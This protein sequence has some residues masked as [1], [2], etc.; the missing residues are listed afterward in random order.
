MFHK[1][2]R[3]LIVLLVALAL[4]LGPA[5]RPASADIYY[6]VIK[7]YIDLMDTVENDGGTEVAVKEVWYLGGWQWRWIAYTTTH[8][9]GYYETGAYIRSNRYY[10]VY[11]VPDLDKVPHMAFGASVY[12]DPDENNPGEKWCSGSLPNG[13]RVP[14]DDW[15]IEQD[16]PQLAYAAQSDINGDGIHDVTDRSII[17]KNLSKVEDNPGAQYPGREYLEWDSSD[18]TE[19]SLGDDAFGALMEL[20]GTI[21]LTN[22]VAPPYEQS[23]DYGQIQAWCNGTSLNYPPATENQWF[24]YGLTD[25]GGHY[26]VSLAVPPTLGVFIMVGN[27]S[28]NLDP[29]ANRHGGAVPHAVMMADTRPGYDN[30]AHWDFL[31]E[32]GNCSYPDNHWGVGDGDY[33][34]MMDSYNLC[35]GQPGFD[36]RADLNDDG[37]VDIL[38]YSIL[39]SNFGVGGTGELPVDAIFD[40]DN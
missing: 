21:S 37:C 13:F 9:T 28:N 25:E 11:A 32:L 31:L 24:Q 19:P 16:S 6:T 27:N 23:P 29:S 39:A 10:Q 5:A 33:D 4:V 7:G 22:D 38:D 12:W 8:T 1:L 20:E 15:T 36:Y 18:P 35:E 34:I 40:V 30:V 17:A 2:I 3:P 14:G 26:I